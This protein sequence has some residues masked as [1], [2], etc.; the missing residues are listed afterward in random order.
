MSSY[1]IS[2]TSFIKF[3]Q[4]EKAFFLYKQHPYLRDK[5]T[6]DKQLTFRRGH[7]VGALAQQLFPGGTDVSAL[8]KNAMDGVA[9]TASLLES[10]TEV[11]YEATFLHRGVLIM[12]DILHCENGVYRAYEVKSSLKVS[13][14]YLKD[15]YLQYYVLK[16][17]L[18]K[19]EDFFLVTL[20]ADYVLD[21]ELDV[22]KLFK[23]RSVKIKAEENLAY[24]EHR[25]SLAHEVLERNQIPNMAV[26]KHCFRPYTCDFFGTCWKEVMVEDSI[27][28]LPLIDKQRLFD[29]YSAGYKRIP[30]LSATQ[31]EKESWIKLK[32]AI[33]HRTTVI[34]KAKIADFLQRIKAPLAAMDMEIWSA[35]IPR[36]QGTSPFE[37][38]PFLASFYDGH[39]YKDCFSALE[40][41]DLEPF[42]KELI[43][44]S[45]SYASI[46]VYDKT[47]E[48]AAIQKLIQRFEPLRPELEALKD[49]LL[50]VFEIFLGLS[51]YDP[52][53]KSNFSLKGVSQVLLKDVDYQGIGSGLEA[54][55]YFE[56]LRE[57]IDP[58]EKQK[59][60]QELI[61]YCN[62]DCR[63]TFGLAEFFKDLVA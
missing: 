3:E 17:C 55:N 62:T 21:G 37:Q 22:K 18:P 26:G 40:T 13:E 14:T 16:A 24:F 42:A 48:V 41:Q 61:D 52:A 25:I 44:V 60:K 47:M 32:E 39:T 1:S 6:V 54:M 28:H 34:D 36:L 59:L 33:E 50:D 9:L 12:V 11:I 29:W 10:K 53:F 5:L 43:R 20:Q 63:A 58:F 27:F 51:Y 45:S 56:R 57:A 7:D 19:L 49:K 2:K 46:L 31:L 35:A 4:C 38:L 30:E 15:A 23:R 8:C